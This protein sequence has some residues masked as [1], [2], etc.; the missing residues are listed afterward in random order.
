MMYVKDL[1]LPNKHCPMAQKW[2]LDCFC[3]LLFLLSLT[4]LSLALD[5]YQQPLRKEYSDPFH[6]DAF[7]HGRHEEEAQGYKIMDP[8]LAPNADKVKMFPPLPD[9]GSTSS[10]ELARNPPSKVMD[11]GRSDKAAG[12]EP[13]NV[14]EGSIEFTDGKIKGLEEKGNY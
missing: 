14:L 3:F 6:Q 5:P 9:L 7:S 11:G 2:K 10:T 4:S 13:K 1:L 8:G 12:T